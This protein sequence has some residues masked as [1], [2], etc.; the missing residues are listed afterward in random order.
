MK[1]LILVAVLCLPVG[2]EAAKK[3]VGPVW[4]E[5]PKAP[6][7]QADGSFADNAMTR[8]AIE[9]DLDGSDVLAIEDHG[10]VIHV[11]IESEA[12]E[13]GESVIDTALNSPWT[14]GSLAVL[15]LGAG[16]IVVKRRGLKI[17]SQPEPTPAPTEPPKE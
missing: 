9:S 4:I 10:A 13:L 2:C 17:V 16:R 5:L 11:K 7:A 15:L 3:F 14:W 6:Y 8:Q 12:E 1:R